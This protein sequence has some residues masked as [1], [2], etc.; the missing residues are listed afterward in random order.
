VLG[1]GEPPAPDDPPDPDGGLM[2]DSSQP[3]TGETAEESGETVVAEEGFMTAAGDGGDG[4]DACPLVDILFVVDNS[5]SMG[6]E[7]EVL[8]SSIEGFISGIESQLSEENDFHLGVVTS[9]QYA[10]NPE[11]F[12]DTATTEIYTPQGE[13][14][15]YAEGNFMSA[16]D[17]LDTSFPCAA[18][19]GIDG[20]HDERTIAAALAAVAEPDSCNDAFIRDDSLL[21]LVLVSDEDDSPD[22][23]TDNLGSMGGPADWYQQM[24]DLRG[25]IEHNIVVLSIIGVS[26]SAACEGGESSKPGVRLN[27]F[28]R[29]FTWWQVADVC[30]SDYSDFFTDALSLVEVACSGFTPP[31]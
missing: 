15:P 6:R 10:H 21:V 30:G 19:V 8:A 1:I 11:F 24:V 12:N 13:C 28:T 29:S 20:D 18:Q 2:T 4:G 14:G 5:N 27:E 31:G 25:G 16:M 23:N 7:Q 26:D 3:D 17:E 22:P 9:D